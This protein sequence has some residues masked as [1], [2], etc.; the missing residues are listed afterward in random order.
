MNSFKKTMIMNNLKINGIILFTCIF[1][2][3][4][5]DLQQN[6]DYEPASLPDPNLGMS[7]T[8]FFATFVPKLQT[9]RENGYAFTTLSEA[10]ERTGLDETL[11]GGMYTIFAPNDLAFRRFF[12]SNE[13]Y[14]SLDDIP[15]DILKS[16]IEHHIVEGKF[17]LEDFSNEPR[18]LTP[19]SGDDLEVLTND[20]PS[21]MRFY[22]IFVNNIQ[23]RT[24]NLEPTNGAIHVI[25][26]DVMAE[27]AF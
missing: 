27:G 24:S 7:A 14:D 11:S 19:L 25:F 12:E 16:I 23:V 6:F 9:S 18:L 26:A 5:C 22:R 1:F 3:S 15:T 13:N 21:V 2:F 10:L 4:G 20:A 17:L 8:E